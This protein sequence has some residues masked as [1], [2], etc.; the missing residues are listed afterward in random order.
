MRSCLF[1][2]LV[3]PALFGQSPAA[4][5][6]TSV[7]YSAPLPIAV[8]P[9]QVITLFVRTASIHLDAPVLAGVPPLPST[10]AGFS[11]GLNQTFASQEQ[12]VPILS[13]A[14]A[15][16]CTAVNPVVCNTFT[17]LTVQIPFE[18][19]PNFEDSRL[20]ANFATLV[21]YENGAA[22]DPL[23]LNPVFARIHVVTSC[24]STDVNVNPP[25]VPLVLHADGSPVTLQKPA[26]TQELL[27]VKLYGVG[28]ADSNI[29]SGAKPAAA[30]PV[31]GISLY[32]GFG[33]GVVELP[34]VSTALS[35]DAV[36]LYTLVFRAPSLPQGTP[37]CAA[38]GVTNA[39][40]VNISV[41][42]GTTTS[43]DA[44]AI[45]VQ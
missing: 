27:S 3:F 30:I 8:A 44:A 41:L 37:A 34:V 36:G 40:N 35:S 2:L 23:L 1:A 19:Q 42:R 15:V 18:L 32:A 14:P 33:N 13:A 45:C 9:G 31:S 25:C 17:A 22:G 4:N 26:K 38:E 10:L 16:R 21:V 5:V 24:D 20:P 11:V 12:P 6:V 39:T 43:L 7:G 29:A 28:K